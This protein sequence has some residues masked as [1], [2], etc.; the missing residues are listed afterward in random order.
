MSHAY[1]GKPVFLEFDINEIYYTN[2]LILL[3]TINCVVIFVDV[4]LK[5]N[6][7]PRINVS[8]LAGGGRV[9]S[10]GVGCPTGSVRFREKRETTQKVLT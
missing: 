3:V 4:K 2:V 1:P 8:V 10:R 6:R 7:F 9:W 5:K